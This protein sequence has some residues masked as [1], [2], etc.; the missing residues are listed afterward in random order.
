MT[1]KIETSHF[2]REI[3]DGDKAQFEYT[4]KGD[5]RN[6]IIYVRL[7]DDGTGAFPSIA[8][9]DC[10]PS[11]NVAYT[12]A[13]IAVDDYFSLTTNNATSFNLCKNDT[14]SSLSNPQIEIIESAKHGVALVVSDSVISYKSNDGFQGIDT[15]RYR[16]RCTY[17]NLTVVSEAMV[18]VLTLKPATMEYVACPNTVVQLEMNAVAG[19]EYSWFKDEK[20]GTVLSGGSKTNKYKFVKGAANETLWVQ[21]DIKN[22]ILNLFPRFRINILLAA[23]CNQL[24]ECTVNGRLLFHEDFGGN[25][26]STDNVAPNGNL[27]TV[28]S[29]VYSTS[30]VNNSYTIRKVS[31][32]KGGLPNNIDDHTYPGDKYR[33]QMLQFIATKAPGQFYKYQLDNLC[34]GLTLNISAWMVNLSVRPKPSMIFEISDLNGN[35]FSKYYI[36]ME[37]TKFAWKN[38]GFSFTVPRNVNSLI[39]KIVNNSSEDNSFLIDD[40]EIRLCVPKVTIRDMRTDTAVCVGRSLTFRGNYPSG[41]NPFGNDLIYRWEFRHRD[42]A[43]WEILIENQD[44]PPLNIVYTIAGVAKTNDGYYR[45]RVSNPE[46][47]GSMNCCAVSDSLHLNVLEFIRFPDIR[48]QLS[49]MPKRTINLSSFVDSVPHTSIRWE[50]SSSASPAIIAGT[51][52]TT[53]SVNSAD[54][55]HA[56]TYTYEYNVSSQCDVSKAKTYIRTL[57]DKI[58]HTPDTIMICGSVESNSILNL[59]HLLGLELGGTWKYDNTVNPDPTVSN[60]VTVKSPP[61]KFAGALIFDAANAWS[62]APT[63]YSLNYKGHNDA[64]IFKFIY[65]PI[66]GSVYDTRRELVIIVTK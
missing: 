48:I 44:T 41:G 26:Y 14:F 59:N 21:A 66:T 61:S 54:F 3:F 31:G 60:N 63:T 50:S 40:I 7:V 53:G 20:G 25:L 23:N 11:N 10:N 22:V 64:K 51:H 32:G 12:M 9:I 57:K 46:Y 47:I 56:G 34:E 15:I 13:A 29:Y 49:P 33:G 4:I 18:Y 28:A 62:T 65:Y 52:E 16:L 6:Q 1:N 37:D 8:H 19:V 35:V 38:Y 30:Y 45:L 2:R 27:S 55:I 43:K 17:N 39:F 36:D 24:S 58:M 5:H 42:S